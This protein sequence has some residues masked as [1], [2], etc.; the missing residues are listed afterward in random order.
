MRCSS[1]ASVS[2][3]AGSMG[4]PAR[5][6]CDQYTKLWAM[7]AHQSHGVMGSLPAPRLGA[8]NL[9][10]AVPLSVHLS[11]QQALRLARSA[12]DPTAILRDMDCQGSSFACSMTPWGSGPHVWVTP[13]DHVHSA[14]QIGMVQPCVLVPVNPAK[15]G[16]AH[17]TYPVCGLGSWC[18]GC[19]CSHRP[20]PTDLSPPRAPV[21]D[22]PEIS[23]TNS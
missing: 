20:P 18:G 2:E 19:L 23:P 9:C 11:E 17:K 12:P 3:A 10:T 6:R 16:T 14:V 7:Q 5:A 4:S 1:R 22:F 15:K 21:S 8:G 13:R